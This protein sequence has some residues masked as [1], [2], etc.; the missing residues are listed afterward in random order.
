MSEYEVWRKRIGNNANCWKRK[1]YK[2]CCCK[3]GEPPYICAY[4]CVCTIN[5]EILFNNYQLYMPMRI[6]VMN[7]MFK[8][9]LHTHTH[10]YIL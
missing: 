5:D 1:Y 2:V 4:N 3:H 7:T 8:I 9:Y 6:H 10:I